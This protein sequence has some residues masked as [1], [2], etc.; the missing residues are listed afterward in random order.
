MAL[1]IQLNKKVKVIFLRLVQQQL[2]TKPH[3][4]IGQALTLVSQG[5]LALLQRL[6]KMVSLKLKLLSSLLYLLSSVYIFIKFINSLPNPWLQ[7]YLDGF[8]I[9][10]RLVGGWFYY[11]N[12]VGHVSS[13]INRTEFIA[14]KVEIGVVMV[15]ILVLVLKKLFLRR[16]VICLELNSPPIIMQS[17]I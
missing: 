14:S 7:F 4:I 3:N 10:N 8:I 2:N 13:I 5:I 12:K 6:Q 9:V 1:Q 17:L 11:T 15:L 16:Q